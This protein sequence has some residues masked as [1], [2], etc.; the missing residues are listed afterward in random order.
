[1]LMLCGLL[2]ERFKLKLP[3]EMRETQ[4]F[5]AVRDLGLKLESERVPLEHLVIESVESRRKIRMP[6]GNNRSVAGNSSW[7]CRRTAR[8]LG[9]SRGSREPPWHRRRRQP[10]ERRGSACSRTGKPCDG[11][12]PRNL[13][14]RR[15][16]AVTPGE[17]VRV[18]QGISAEGILDT[19][20]QVAAS[21]HSVSFRALR[22]SACSPLVSA[23]GRSSPREP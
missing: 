18:W 11:A 21:R 20:G 12:V 6:S 23:R 8:G 13:R 10:L 9:R 7:T 3:G 15:Y 4:I 19:V 17:S 14:E 2:A 5:D 22:R 16:K 1:M